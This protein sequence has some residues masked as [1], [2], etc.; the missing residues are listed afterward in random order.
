MTVFNT[1][2]TQKKYYKYKECEEGQVLVT[3]KYLGTSPNKFNADK[4]NFDFADEDG[5]IVCL[6]SA[7]HL[8]WLVNTYLKPGQ[9]CRVTFAGKDTLSKGT[10][11]GKEVNRFELALPEGAEVGVYETVESDEAVNVAP[12]ESVDLDGLD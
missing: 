2:S 5:T 9:L 8:S 4:P 11:K 7:G 12:S 1:V 3:G 6:N 10:F